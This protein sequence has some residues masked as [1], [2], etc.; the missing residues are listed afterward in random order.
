MQLKLARLGRKVL[1]SAVLVLGLGLM[2]VPARAQQ[3]EIGLTLGNIVSQDRTA[4]EGTK[5]SLSSATALQANYAYRLGGARLASVSIGVHFLANGSR[6]I[7][8]AN[9]TLPRS[10]ATLYVTPDVIVKFLHGGRVQPWG[11]IGGGYAQYESS[12]ELLDG[13][14]NGGKIRIHRGALVYG[15]GID[16]AIW[17]GLAL[18]GEVR[19]FY[20]GSP[21]LNVPLP[22]GQHNVVAGGGFVLR[23]GH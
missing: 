6:S 20:T 15:G 16:V 1:Y 17:S 12:K 2:S 5:L 18:R 10:V 13:S 8:S 14:A 22:G 3:H 19:D 7:S 23:F 9:E 21:S 4:T 11:T